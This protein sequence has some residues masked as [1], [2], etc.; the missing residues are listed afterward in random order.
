MIA[1]PRS[2]V[3]ETPVA[4]ARAIVERLGPIGGHWLDPCAGSGVFLDAVHSFGV[5]DAVSSVDVTHYS[6][7]SS[8]KG[9]IQDFLATCPLSLTPDVIIANPPYVPV[10][11]LNPSLRKSALNCTFRDLNV[12]GKSS[13]WLPFVLKSLRL[14][15]KG[16]SVAFIL[17]AAYEYADYAKALRETMPSLFQ[18]FELHRSKTPLFSSVSDGCIVLLAFGFLESNIS[19]LRFEHS[20]IESL[21]SFFNSSCS[22]GGKH[23][24]NSCYQGQK[25]GDHAH[26]SIGAVSGDARYFVLSEDQLR[27]SNIPT[28]ACLPVLSKSS[29]VKA[30]LLQQVSIKNVQCSPGVRHWLFTPNE[31]MSA[32][33]GIREYLE[34]GL[35]GG[36]KVQNF[37][38]KNRPIWYSI[39]APEEPD[40][41][42]TGMFTAL[43]S[44]CGLES[45]VSV[46]NTLYAITCKT[47]KTLPEKRAFAL[48]FFS[49]ETV[50]AIAETARR[51]PDGLLKL[52]P[53]QVMDL[54]LLQLDSSRIDDKILTKVTE[55][56]ASGQIQACSKLV[57][58]LAS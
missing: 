29:Q 56:V 54:P 46:T 45:S 58:S 36:C 13:Y 7:P 55:L 43:P 57:D 8:V 11:R 52:E 31:E 12:S 48:S 28:T 37:K 35:S 9:Y 33:P 44:I 17:P 47:K 53:R 10:S 1:V 49:S 3:V 26:V 38:V 40:F 20:G 22:E 39:Y 50:Q 15:N 51:Y 25:I 42:F 21:I 4:L 34:Y 32:N 19:Q 5:A 30:N 41:A 2:C 6:W 18:C 23:L 24:S 27:Q 16:G 14:L